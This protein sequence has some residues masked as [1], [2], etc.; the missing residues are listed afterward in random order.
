MYK[1]PMCGEEH[2]YGKKIFHKCQNNELFFGSLVSEKKNNHPWNA[3]YEPQLIKKYQSPRDDCL[4][5]EK[6]KQLK[7]ILSHLKQK[8][9]KELK[10][11]LSDIK[12]KFLCSEC[13]IN[14]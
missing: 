9:K 8:N 10:E 3:Q 4:D 14:K 7:E 12:L 11:A 1:C 2:S 6:E 5:C 13:E